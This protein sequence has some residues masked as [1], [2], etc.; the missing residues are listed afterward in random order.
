ME[1]LKAV[2]RGALSALTIALGVYVGIALYNKF[3]SS[4]GGAATVTQ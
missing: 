2:T 4:P 3:G 1:G